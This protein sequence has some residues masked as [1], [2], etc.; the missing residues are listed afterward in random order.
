MSAAADVRTVDAGPVQPVSLRVNFAWTSVGHASYAACQWA[1]VSVLAKLGSPELVGQYALGIAATAPIL[2]LAQMNLRSVL[3][4]DPAFGARFGDYRDLRLGMLLLALIGIA[5]GAWMNGAGTA[6]V[7]FAGAAQ[8]VEWFSD[9]YHGLYQR[10]ERM[11]RIAISLAV[12]GVLS[13]TALAVVVWS[14]GSLVWG[15]AAVTGVR[16]LVLVVYDSG[17]AY[18]GVL[19]F[20]ADGADGK[21]KFARLAGLVW[22]AL[23][24]GLVLMLGSL[25]TNTPRYAI[26]RDLGQHSLG[27]FSAV[28]SLATAGNFVVN[29]LGQA[30]TPALARH[31]ESGQMNQFRA[32]TLKLVAVGC[33]LCLLTVAGSLVAGE[34]I[35]RI[36]YREE[37]ARESNLLIAFMFAAGIG[38]VAS[39]LGY[40]MT[41]CRLFRS[42]VPLQMACLATTAAASFYCVPR[43]GLM[44]AA[45]AVGAG[46]GVQVLA[47]AAIL[48]RFMRAA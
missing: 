46:C 17:L 4:T 15:L 8:A 41:A 9:I 35:L 47:E 2:M 11:E 30:A 24:L 36:A 44:G 38:Y 37:Y 21:P 5:V 31:R 1:M 34:F 20:A 26:A 33:G 7:V 43:L 48:H 14:T 42:Q 19:R 12:R 22:T 40:S 23:P 28:A 39:L 45:V 10:M 29:A 13:V 18:R 25:V 6:V 16:L 27:L 3:A 32:L